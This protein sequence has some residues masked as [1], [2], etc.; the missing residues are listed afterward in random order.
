MVLELA[1]GMPAPWFELPRD[2][3]GNISLDEFAGR[4]LVLYFFPRADTPGCTL[5]AQAFSALQ[6]SF[7]QARTTVLG[8]SADP[9]AA[10]DRF[11]KKYGLQIP[12]A[13]DETRRMLQEYG[14]WIEKSMYGRRYMGVERATFLLGLDG[15]FARIWRNVKVKGHADE[16][17]AAARAL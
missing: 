15:R 5:E 16:V 9:I 1:A 14:V 7:E 8:V 10:Q 4:K 11:K 17:L 3:G 6:T 12:L 2:G 13:S